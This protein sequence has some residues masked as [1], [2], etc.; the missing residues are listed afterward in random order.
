[1]T[2][3][4]LSVRWS[5][6]ESYVA[7]FAGWD[8]TAASWEATQITDFVLIVKKGLRKFYYPPAIPPETIPYE[9][10]FLRPTATHTLANGDWDYDLPENFGGLVLPRSVVYSTDQTGSDGRRLRKISPEELLALRIQGAAT[11]TPL[12]WAQRQLVYVPTTGH[13]YEMLFYPTPA[14]NEANDVITYRYVV[15]PDT[16]TS[17]NMFPIGG[18]LHSECIIEAVL[19]AA[20]E[21]LDDEPNGIHSQKFQALLGASIRVD[22]EAKRQV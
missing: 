3:S 7:I 16:I 13:R 8:R 11:G 19:S 2:E 9:W 14:A 15:A 4:T 5:D 20:E 17:T 6:L 10:D 21:F 12:Y 22:Q 18:T 1:M